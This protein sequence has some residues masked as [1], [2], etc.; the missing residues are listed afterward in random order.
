MCLMEML[1]CVCEKL[2]PLCPLPPL[3]LDGFGGCVEY[4]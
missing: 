4:A 1:C 2:R 3:A